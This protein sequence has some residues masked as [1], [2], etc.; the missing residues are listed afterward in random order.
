MGADDEKLHSVERRPDERQDF[1]DEVDDSILV[2][3]MAK[4]ADEHDVATRCE[5]RNVR[6]AA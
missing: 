1:F 2:R 5:R 3:G 6:A 4:A